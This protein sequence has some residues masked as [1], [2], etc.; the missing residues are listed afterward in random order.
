[1]PSIVRAKTISYCISEYRHVRWQAKLK[2]A[3]TDRCPF[4]RLFRT[5]VDR[6]LPES[7]SQFVD[8]KSIAISRINTLEFLIPPPIYIY[9]FINIYCSNTSIDKGLMPL[10]LLHLLLRQS[11]SLPVL[12]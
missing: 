7:V 4:D 8:S 3:V 12:R 1:M 6:I 2:A 9:V 5:D 11:I 10:F